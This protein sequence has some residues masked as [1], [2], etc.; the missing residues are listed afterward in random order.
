MESGNIISGM[1]FEKVLSG[2]THGI[3]K[4]NYDATLLATP[5][6][7]KL[8]IWN[9]AT[10]K[11]T[12]EFTS[13]DPINTIAFSP[14]NNIAIASCSNLFIWNCTRNQRIKKINLLEKSFLNGS[15]SYS[16][17]FLAFSPDGT[18]LATG[19][20]DGCRVWSVK[21]GKRI[22]YC[23]DFASTP[24]I[25][26]TDNNQLVAYNDHQSHIWNIDNGKFNKTDCLD[27]YASSYSTKTDD[28]RSELRSITFTEYPSRLIK[29]KEHEYITIGGINNKGNEINQQKITLPHHDHSIIN[30]Y[31]IVVPE[32]DES[33]IVLMNYHTLYLLEQVDLM[34]EQLTLKQVLYLLMLS[35]FP[36][37]DYFRTRSAQE[38]LASLPGPII[39][40]LCDQ[41]NLVL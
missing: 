24:R 8:Y 12:F 16:L 23:P 29:I 20:Q 38:I 40:S 18:M 30:K 17:E 28:P 21:T 25:V 5:D 36:E 3:D 22:H 32:Y 10:G 2:R 26:F 41:Y 35:R 1:P 14:S 37:D 11:C 9:V 4:F 15:S 34:N 6:R 33:H 39:K 27:R 13:D 31:R 19:S 7:N